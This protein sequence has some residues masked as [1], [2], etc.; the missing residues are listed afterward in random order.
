MEIIAPKRT[1]GI[2]LDVQRETYEKVPK[3]WKPE[4]TPSEYE[5]TEG[6]DPNFDLK[7]I[8]AELESIRSAQK[9]SDLVKTLKIGNVN[10]FK[11]FE[12]WADSNNPSESEFRDLLHDHMR[13]SRRALVYLKD[14]RKEVTHASLNLL[15]EAKKR[16]AEL[17]S[18]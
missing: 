5:L 14:G 10:D 4:I 12:D 11:I 18:N 9:V 3:P 13:W 7:V 1:Y 17:Q 16:Y 15:R 6:T 2:P 8:E